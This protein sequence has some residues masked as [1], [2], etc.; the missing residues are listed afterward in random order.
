MAV[1]APMQTGAGIQNKVLETMA[2]GTINVLTSLAAN[3]I[4]GAI[5]GE[6]FLIANTADDF[7]DIL[8]KIA[9]RPDEYNNIKMSA[10]NF[11][12]QN[13][14]WQICEKQYMQ[15]IESKDKDKCSSP[16][17]AVP[18]LSAPV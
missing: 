11:I 16:S 8:L 10:R 15:A 5:D 14:T 17:S 1:V 13:Y 4:V 6:H 18:A 2:L 9:A 12:A 3:P 7:C